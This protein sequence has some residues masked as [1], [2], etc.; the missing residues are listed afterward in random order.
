[1]SKINPIF[2]GIVNSQNKIDFKDKNAFYLWVSTFRENTPVEVIVRRQ[3]SNRSLSQNN[4]Y[5]AVIV[6]LISSET[7]HDEDEIHELLK[8]MFL[9]KKIIIKGKEYEMAGSSAMLDTIGFED[10]TEKCRKFAAEELNIV[11]PLPGEI[12]ISL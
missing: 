5:W 12:E 6:T 2:E 9:K 8:A 3:R 10:Y 4:Y 1:M 11:V 7:G